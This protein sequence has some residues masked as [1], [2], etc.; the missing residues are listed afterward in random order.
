MQPQPPQQPAQAP[1]PAGPPPPSPY[2]YPY[3]GYYPPPPPRSDSSKIIVIVVIVVIVIVLITIIGAAVLYV[4]VSGLLTGPGT[5]PRAMGVSIAAS[6]DGSNWT[7]TIQTTPA[8]EL[9]ASTYLLIRNPQ[10]VI[11]LARTAF[12]GLTL[13]N[14]NIYHALFQD[15]NPSSTT[16]APGD[17][18]VISRVTYPPGSTLEISDDSGVLTSRTLNG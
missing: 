16:L 8:G 15:A 12:S 1:P 6:A 14:W 2:P 17:G 4:M 7:V 11:S 5:G 18:L 9:P 10:G 3:P 13:A